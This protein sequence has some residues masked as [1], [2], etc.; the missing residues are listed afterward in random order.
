[1]FGLIPQTMYT[2]MIQVILPFGDLIVQR[3]THPLF[4]TV[5][6][7]KVVFG[8]IQLDICTLLTTTTMDTTRLCA[9]ICPRVL[10]RL[11]LDR[12]LTTRRQL[13]SIRLCIKFLISGGTLSIT[14]TWS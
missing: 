12:R 3:A 1:M 2:S 9:R 13:Q 5:I 8:V 11:L 10:L 14:C 7:G 4:I 6:P